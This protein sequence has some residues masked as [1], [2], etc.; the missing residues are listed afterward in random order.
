MRSTHAQKEIRGSHFSPML[1][2]KTLKV[3]SLLVGRSSLQSC[4]SSFLARLLSNASA[5]SK[6]KVFMDIAADGKS[7]GRVTIEV[8]EKIVLLLHNK[9]SS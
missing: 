2:L 9:H 4:H 1:T 8:S 7:L 6:T 3:T 5:M